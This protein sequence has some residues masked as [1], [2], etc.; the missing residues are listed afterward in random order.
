MGRTRGFT[1]A[2]GARAAQSRKANIAAR[3]ASPLRRNFM[4]APNWRR[5]ASGRG[6]IL[7]AWGI[8]PTPGAMERWLKK[9]GMSVPA[10]LEWAGERTLKDFAAANSLWPLRAWVGCLLEEEAA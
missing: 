3:R 2:E 4:D 9:L 5:L 10:Y 1:Q 6:V 8:P 7:P